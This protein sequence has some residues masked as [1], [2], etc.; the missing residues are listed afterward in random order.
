VVEVIEV[1]LAVLFPIVHGV[2]LALLM[3]FMVQEHGGW[4]GDAPRFTQWPPESGHPD[5]VGVG[6]EDPGAV[7][8]NRWILVPSKEPYPV[9]AFMWANIAAFGSARLLLA[10]AAE[11]WGEFKGPYPYGISYTT[12][13]AAIGAG[14]SFLQWYGIG[15]LADVVR[16]RRARRRPAP[17]RS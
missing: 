15:A 9:V 12:Y 11:V 3:L 17:R 13:P 6:S 2:L 5:A 1:R 4:N 14:L 7:L 10:G 8:C 16:A